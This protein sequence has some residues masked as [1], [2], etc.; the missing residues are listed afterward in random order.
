LLGPLATLA[1]WCQSGTSPTS[2]HGPTA[3][4]LGDL[5]N[6]GVTIPIRASA[7]TLVAGL[8]PVKPHLGLSHLQL[9]HSSS[10]PAA[11]RRRRYLAR[12]PA[13]RSPAIQREWSYSSKDSNRSRHWRIAASWEALRH[14]AN[15]RWWTP[16]DGHRLVCRVIGD[17]PT[18]GE[19]RQTACWPGRTQ[20]RLLLCLDTAGTT[21][22]GVRPNGTNPGRL[23]N[24]EWTEP[25]VLVVESRQ[26]GGCEQPNF[27]HRL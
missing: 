27:D 23:A 15:K 1:R 10:P 11:G 25:G 5:D 19:D 14:G 12:S 3:S 24:R 21:R 9:L 26:I 6:E 20:A 22:R 8:W 4:P 13:R 17:L 18:E 2:T 16:V 7:R